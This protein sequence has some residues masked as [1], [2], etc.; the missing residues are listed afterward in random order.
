MSSFIPPMRCQHCGNTNITS[1]YLAFIEITTNF[2]N[3][4]ILYA[5][6]IK[7]KDII[8]PSTSKKILNDIYKNLGMKNMNNCCSNTI[9]TLPL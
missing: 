3:M 6:D 4:N 2:E 1:I 9:L 7:N 5:D 8:E